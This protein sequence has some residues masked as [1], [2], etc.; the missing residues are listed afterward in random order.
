MSYDANNPIIAISNVLV[1]ISTTLMH[2]DV[3]CGP[4]YG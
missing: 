1:D 3:Q 2:Y 4:A